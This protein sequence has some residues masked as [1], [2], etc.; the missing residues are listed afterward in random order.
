MVHPELE[1]YL[2][3]EQKVLLLF[4]PGLVWGGRRPDSMLGYLGHAFSINTW[5]WGTAGPVD[6][7]LWCHTFRSLEWD[8]TS[9]T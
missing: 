9:V 4:C 2:P 7:D 6:S 3:L 1:V 5:S 8:A